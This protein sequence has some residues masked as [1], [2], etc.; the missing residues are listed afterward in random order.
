[1]IGKRQRSVQ[2]ILMMGSMCTTH[3]FA[4]RSL[5]FVLPPCRVSAAAPVLQRAECVL[6]AETPRRVCLSP[7]T[8][9]FPIGMHGHE[10]GHELPCT[11]VPPRAQVWRLLALHA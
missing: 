7:S 6:H 4:F 2:R 11:R 9:A 1:M 10:A 8:L 5:V 3:T